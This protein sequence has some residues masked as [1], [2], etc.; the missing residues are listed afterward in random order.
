[1]VN[2]QALLA[3]GSQVSYPNGAFGF[4]AERDIV[5]GKVVSNRYGVKWNM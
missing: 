3:Q 1:M 2:R 4:V 5:P